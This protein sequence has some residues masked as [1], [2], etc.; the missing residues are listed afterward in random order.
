MHVIFQHHR[1][2]A[3][4]AFGM[5]RLMVVH[6]SDGTESSPLKRL[7]CLSSIRQSDL[8]VLKVKPESRCLHDLAFFALAVTSG[9]IYRMWK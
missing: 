8:S 1:N 6:M 3:Q 2:V 7:M 5:N 4:A 9:T